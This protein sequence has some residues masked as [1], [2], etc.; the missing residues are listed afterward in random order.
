MHLF[1]R[2]RALDARC[3][4]QVEFLSADAQ[5]FLL[6]EIAAVIRLPDLFALTLKGGLS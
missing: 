3:A 4:G 1:V 2:H 5:N 6:G